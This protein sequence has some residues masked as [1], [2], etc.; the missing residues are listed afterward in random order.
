VNK[1]IKKFGASLSHKQCSVFKLN[2]ED[3]LK[4]GC[5]LG[6]E[7]IR[8]P[9]YWS[10]VQKIQNNKLDFSLIDKQ[11][12]ILKKYDLK[13][14][15]QFGVKSLWWPEFYFPKG[16]SYSEFFNSDNSSKLQSQY[17]EYISE[18]VK[19]YD[20]NRQ[21]TCYQIENEPFNPAGK[22]NDTIPCDFLKKE[23][24]L[25]KKLSAKPIISSGFVPT[26]KLAILSNLRKNFSLDRVGIQY[27]YKYERPKWNFLDNFVF[28]YL[29]VYMF[30]LGS[31]TRNKFF[32]SELQAQPWLSKDIRAKI[33]LPGQYAK[34]LQ[35]IIKLP[36]DEFWFWG[37]EFWS[38][39]IEYYQ[40]DTWSKMIASIIKEC[41]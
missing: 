10:D 22:H 17:L 12:K 24:K 36:I 29:R 40:D 2:W 41:K 38:F 21:I 28:A 6:L 31:K 39:R 35:K 26:N 27:Y 4:L 30:F 15:L 3:C 1:K 34:K 23:V 5:E 33:S 9:I 18:L 32:F 19:R 16:I 8:I 14:C 11:L 37:L 20:H 13:V 7:L 25:I